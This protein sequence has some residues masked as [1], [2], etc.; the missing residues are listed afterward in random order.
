MN[1]VGLAF[2]IVALLVAVIGTCLVVSKPASAGPP[3]GNDG[4]SGIVSSQL[5]V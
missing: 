4:H 1:R 5:G 3:T 2:G